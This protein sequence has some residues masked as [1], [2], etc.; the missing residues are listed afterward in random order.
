VVHLFFPGAE[1]RLWITGIH[2]ALSAWLVIR[3]WRRVKFLLREEPEEE[4]LSRSG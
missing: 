2:F 4:R 3:D 1:E